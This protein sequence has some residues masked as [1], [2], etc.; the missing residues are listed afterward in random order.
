MKRVRIELGDDGPV[1]ELPAG[2]VWE[3]ESRTVRCDSDNLWVV[4]VSGRGKGNAHRGGNGDGDV[5][6]SG[7]GD[8][9]TTREGSGVGS[10]MRWGDGDGNAIRDG[11]GEGNAVR[12][13]FGRGD[14][15]RRG[16]GRG[17][18][19][20]RGYGRGDAIRSG[21]G[22]GNAYCK[23]S[24]GIA[25]RDGEGSG[26]ARRHYGKYEFTVNGTLITA[27][28]EK[29]SARYITRIA[30][31]R[32]AIKQGAS[33]VSGIPEHYVLQSLNPNREFKFDDIVNL[34]EYKKLTARA[35]F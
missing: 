14:A 10:A 8:G 34:L 35:R 12:I 30:I 18:A 7:S 16:Y 2:L 11:D 6:R 1:D 13:G 4:I 20:R 17:D 31:A 28:I 21:P 29:L 3:A 19:I 9:D 27:D 25:I 24:A 33:S 5:V 26:D 22:D 15:I 23:D 32:L